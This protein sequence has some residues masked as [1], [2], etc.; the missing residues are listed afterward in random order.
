LNKGWGGVGGGGN[1]I[2][3]LLF[4]RNL[5][6]KG[7]CNGLLILRVFWCQFIQVGMGRHTKS[8]KQKKTMH[9][10]YMAAE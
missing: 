3:Q 2:Y 8:Q 9:T 7:R 4:I 1:V 6:T 10:S 5:G